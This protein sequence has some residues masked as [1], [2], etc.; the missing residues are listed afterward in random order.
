MYR[1]FPLHYYRLEAPVYRGFVNL[2]L[3][4]LFVIVSSY[5]E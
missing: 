4:L 3:N 2:C 1:V 5:G